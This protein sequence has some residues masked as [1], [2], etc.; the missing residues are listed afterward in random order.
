VPV[1]DRRMARS[2][3]YWIAW[4][5]AVAI[6]LAIRVLAYEAADDR[7]PLAVTYMFMVLTVGIL[8]WYEAHRVLSWLRQH[9]YAQWKELRS[10]ADPHLR[11]RAWLHEAN[12]AHDP[13]LARFQ[14]EYRSLY[15]L[16]LTAFCSALVIVPLLVL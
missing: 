5:G 10:P 14:R 4:L 16:G 13:D 7:L 2:R 6:V 1:Y 11:L 12:L 3:V 8:Q 15:R 9:R